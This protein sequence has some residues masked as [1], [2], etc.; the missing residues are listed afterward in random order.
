MHNLNKK[1]FLRWLAEVT[2]DIV[3]QVIV[4]SS[5]KAA[6][7]QHVELGGFRIPE[8]DGSCSP[9]A[10]W[11][12]PCSGKS[13]LV[14]H[15]ACFCWC[16]GID[17]RSPVFPALLGTEP[18]NWV[19]CKSREWVDMMWHD[20]SQYT[21]PYLILISIYLH[22]N[23]VGGVDS[24]RTILLARLKCMLRCVAPRW[25]KLPCSVSWERNRNTWSWK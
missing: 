23:T 2:C 14:Q 6:G 10:N 3:V 8:V 19:G 15:S 25:H 17:S 12:W 13:A 16:V 7:A 9:I 21:I 24:F 18:F 20:A 4:P 22:V 5:F 11:N 1:L